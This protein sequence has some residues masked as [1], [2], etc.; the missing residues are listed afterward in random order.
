MTVR[1]SPVSGGVLNQQAKTPLLTAYI[2]YSV[3]K[4][5]RRVS[6]AVS[7]A[8]LFCADGFYA[9]VASRLGCDR[10]IGI[11]SDRDNHFSNA[12]TI[13]ERLGLEGIEFR[14][15]EITPR[16]EFPAADIVGNVGGLYHVEAPKE[17]LALSFRMARKFLIVQ[18]VVSLATDDPDYFETPAP[19]WTWGSRYSRQSFDKMI[20]SSC[21]GIVDHDFNE[22]EGN[23]RPEDRG[24]VYYLIE[25]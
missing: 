25:K 3:A 11:D 1:K 2:A 8:E 9:M 19:G 20:R 5:K 16:S 22:L 18:S 15:D 24:S 23:D 14:K 13:A 6:D 12:K 7:F 21:T 4:C 17:I 10:S